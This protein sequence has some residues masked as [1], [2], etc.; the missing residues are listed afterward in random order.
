MYSSSRLEL[1]TI[2]SKAYL[3][4]ASMPSSILLHALLLFCLQIDFSSISHWIDSYNHARILNLIQNKHFLKSVVSLWGNPPPWGLPLDSTGSTAHR[5][6]YCPATLNHLPPPTLG[7]HCISQCR[8]AALSRGAKRHV[9]PV[10]VTAL[11]QLTSTLCNAACRPSLT[12]V[13]NYS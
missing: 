11:V 10:L 1:G 3:T 4:V 5:P 12:R 13:H 6:H 2:G 7:S 8:G 9:F